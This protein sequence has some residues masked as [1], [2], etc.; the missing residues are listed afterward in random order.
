MVLG[1]HYLFSFAP[2]PLLRGF[3][4]AYQRPSSLRPEAL[5]GP[6]FVKRKSH[7]GGKREEGRGKRAEGRGSKHSLGRRKSARSK[8]KGQKKRKMSAKGEKNGVK[9]ALLLIFRYFCDAKR[10]FP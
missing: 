7:L 10:K 2:Q 5:F 1:T 9:I 4:E 3:S 6:F 8:K